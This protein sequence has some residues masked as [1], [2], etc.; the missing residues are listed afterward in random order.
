[1]KDKENKKKNIFSNFK[2]S[3]TF[4]SPKFNKKL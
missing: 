4:F 1:M 2:T 3:F